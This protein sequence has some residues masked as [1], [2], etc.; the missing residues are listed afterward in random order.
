MQT[1]HLCLHGLTCLLPPLTSSLLPLHK[2]PSSHMGL[3]PDLTFQH[4]RC[5]LRAFAC[6]VV[7]F[8]WFLSLS[9]VRPRPSKACAGHTGSSSP[10]PLSL[11]SLS[12]FISFKS[13]VT[14]RM[15]TMYL[16]VC[17]LGPNAVPAPCICRAICG[18]CQR[19]SVQ[20]ARI[21]PRSSN[22]WGRACP[23]PTQPAGL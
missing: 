2:L 7:A 12:H 15:L 23:V 21:L 16:F 6:A 20:G 1:L 14:L 13:L 22:M 17:L 3:L 5:C 4:T 19:A 9:W 8:A 11:V 18:E 10:P